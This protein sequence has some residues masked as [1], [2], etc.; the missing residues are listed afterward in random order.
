MTPGLDGGGHPG[1]EGGVGVARV[2]RDE[3]RPLVYA[4]VGAH[5]VTGAVAIVQAD[6]PE[7]H[8]RQDVQ[9]VPLRACA[10][11][12]REAREGF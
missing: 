12:E 3:V 2:V 8:A 7:G 9:R 5:A 11:S 1:L 4:Q 6:R 10:R